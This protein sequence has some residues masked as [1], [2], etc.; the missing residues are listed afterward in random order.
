MSDKSI[1][2]N[3]NYLIIREHLILNTYTK[4]ELI[5]RL[6]AKIIYK[7]ILFI[8]NLINIVFPIRGEIFLSN[9]IAFDIPDLLKKFKAFTFERAPTL[10]EILNK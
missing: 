8:N 6:K 3:T 5:K 9:T 2:F 10:L 1:N 4:L 7:G